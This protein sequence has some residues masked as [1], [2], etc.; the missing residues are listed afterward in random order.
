[1]KERRKRKVQLRYRFQVADIRI[2]V[3]A[4]TNTNQAAQKVYCIV[5]NTVPIQNSRRA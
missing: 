5:N 3:N 4:Y 1:M 2:P